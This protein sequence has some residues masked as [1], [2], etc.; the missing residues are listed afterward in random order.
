MRIVFVTDPMDSLDPSIDTSVGLMHAAQDR[1]AEVWVTEACALEVL[2]GRARAL[3]RRVHLAPSSP[4]VAHC[5]TVADPWYAI[6]ESKYIWLDESKAVLM[7]TNP[8]VDTAYLNATFVLDLVD[9]ATT[10]MINDPRGLRLCNEKL[11]ALSFPDLIPPTIVAAD[12]AAIRAFLREHGS[13][14]AKPIDGFAGRGVLR[15]DEGDPN[16]P[17]LIEISTCDGKRPVVVQTFLAQVAHGN[18]RLFLLDGEAVGAVYRYPSKGDFRIGNPSAEAPIT[19]RDRHICA[20]LAPSLARDGLRMVGLDVIGEFL[21][22]TN[23]TSP[24]ALRKADA[25]FGWTL[26]SDLMEHV[27]NSPRDLGG[28]SS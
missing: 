9:P 4:A 13:A 5:W 12:S 18:K 20:R 27:L 28:G 15:L 7:R 21:I 17:S 10:I 26:C 24:G 23:V 16:L 19:E 11:Y 8:P 6:A 3:A 14:V 1:D 22:E 2:D 25:L